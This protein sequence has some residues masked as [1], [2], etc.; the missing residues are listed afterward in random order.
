MA[1]QSTRGVQFA[2]AVRMHLRPLGNTGLLV[3]TLGLGAG[4]IGGHELDEPEVARLLGEALDG[5]LTLIDTARSY[6]LSEV[7]IGRNL[8]HRRHEFVLSTKGGYGV[9]G[10]PDWSAEAVA[11]GIDE[12]LTRL[13]TDY[14]DVFH[15]HSCG[16]EILARED[17]LRALDDARRA[18]KIRVAAY[19]GENEALELAVR[20]RV[21]GAV[22]CSINLC[23][24]RSV[25]GILREASHLDLGVIGKRPLANAS[26][27]F[28]ERPTG[29]YAEAYWDRLRIMRLPLDGGDWLETAL[30]FAAFQP[31][32]SSVIVGTARI[33]H[34]RHNLAAVEKGPLVPA[35]AEHI[36]L[37]FATHD[38][39]WIGQI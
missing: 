8:A 20:S 35:L 27:R 7:R 23:D 14:I 32:V 11:R 19:S 2:W 4:H 13:R 36:R 6:G 26:W 12:A 22:Q 9:D 24:Q 38:H 1:Q 31:G 17:V 21:F 18:G 5:G 37:S 33:D 34:L 3:P 30:R 25:A 10:V 28:T 39:D 29:H 15:L 16:L